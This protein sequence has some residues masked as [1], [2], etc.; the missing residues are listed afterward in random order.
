MLSGYGRLHK[1]AEAVITQI[2]R[3]LSQPEQQRSPHPLEFPDRRDLQNSGSQA[4]DVYRGVSVVEKGGVLGSQAGGQEVVID[5]AY[6]TLAPHLLMGCAQTD[7]NTSLEMCRSAVRVVLV[8]IGRVFQTAENGFLRYLPQGLG[9]GDSID[10][11]W[12]SATTR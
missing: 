11:L 2:H 6:E 3:V 10:A 9:L 1:G 12:T 7:K 4:L 5:A 8:E